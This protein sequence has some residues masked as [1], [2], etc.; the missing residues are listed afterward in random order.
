MKKFDLEEWQDYLIKFAREREWEQFHTPKNL[1][2]AL[3]V[4]ASELLEIFQWE[5]DEGLMSRKEEWQS[6]A[7]DEMADVLVY[8]LRLS[9][10]TGIDLQ[11][12]L[13]QKMQKNAAKYPAEKVRGSSKKYDEY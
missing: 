4:E 5:K 7:A 2:M 6:K 8:L 13:T 9:T 11:K 3:S 10:V 12:A 1:V